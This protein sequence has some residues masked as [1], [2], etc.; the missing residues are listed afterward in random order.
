[1]VLLPTPYGGV[2]VRLCKVV[3]GN[4]HRCRRRTIG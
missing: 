4:I 1:M 2:S 3:V